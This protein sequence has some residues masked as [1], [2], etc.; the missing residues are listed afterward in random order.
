MQLQQKLGYGFILFGFFFT[1][2]MYFAADGG[3]F[4]FTSLIGLLAIF[5]GA[6]QLMIA[7][8]AAAKPAAKTA[9]KSKLKKGHK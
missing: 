8:D 7:A 4:V 5:F 2:A 9:A 3:A 1:L 6:F